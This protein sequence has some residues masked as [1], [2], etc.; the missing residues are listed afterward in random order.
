MRVLSAVTMPEGFDE[1][2]DECIRLPNYTVLLTAEEQMDI[3][4][5]RMLA[6]ERRAGN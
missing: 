1:L 2:G 5:Q 6:A 3:V 4:T